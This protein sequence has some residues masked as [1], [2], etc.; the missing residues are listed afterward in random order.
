[1]PSAHPGTIAQL[2]GWFLKSQLLLSI[3]AFKVFL[4]NTCD[5]SQKVTSGYEIGPVNLRVALYLKPFS[6]GRSLERLWLGLK[7]YLT[8]A[9]QTNVNIFK[10]K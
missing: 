3:D 5:M 4:S 8:K 7:T 2:H 6:E 9:L 10:V 1:M